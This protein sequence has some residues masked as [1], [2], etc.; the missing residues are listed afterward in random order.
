M[1]VLHPLR[2]GA[3]PHIPVNFPG[4]RS[5]QGLWQT[6]GRGWISTQKSGV[7]FDLP[8]FLMEGKEVMEFSWI[9]WII[10]SNI[11]LILLINTTIYMNIYCNNA[12]QT[13]SPFVSDFSNSF[14][15]LAS[16]AHEGQS[17]SQFREISVAGI[18]GTPRFSKM[19]VSEHG[20]YR[21]SPV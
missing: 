12:K 18:G 7:P 19:D 10:L 6:N 20:V 8:I 21:N 9:L 4:S 3:W 2:P 15:R 5:Q 11:F 16:A 13:A 17:T 14:L 1:H